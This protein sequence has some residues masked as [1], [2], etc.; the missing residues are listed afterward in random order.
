VG[1]GGGVSPVSG[2]A[3]GGGGGMM[4][5]G[6]ASWGQPSRATQS[7]RVAAAPLRFA[8]SGDSA[9]RPGSWLDTTA[10]GTLLSLWT[11][12]WTPVSARRACR[13]GTEARFHDLLDRR[14][15]ATATSTSTNRAYERAVRS[16]PRWQRHDASDPSLHRAP[17]TGL[18]TSAYGSAA[19]KR[20]FFSPSPAR[21]TGALRR[22]NFH[23]RSHE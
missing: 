14:V 3:G 20:S 18:I 6:R 16:P 2:A 19:R 22:P 5:Q 15:L 21:H 11:T 13:R 9:P 10:R 1:H 23:R 4:G 17:R 12:I 7:S 8:P